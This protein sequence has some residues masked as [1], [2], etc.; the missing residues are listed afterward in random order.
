MNCTWEEHGMPDERGWRTV[1]CTRCGLITHP[2]PHAFEAIHSE[3]RIPGLGDYTKYGLAIFGVTQNRVAWVRK[4]LGLDGCG[5]CPENQE[6]LN[7]LGKKI[8]L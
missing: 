5:S 8:G 1:R 7:E 3:C 2:T 4:Q 6:A